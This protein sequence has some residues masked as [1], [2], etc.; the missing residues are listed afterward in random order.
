MPRMKSGAIKIHSSFRVTLHA[1]DF[2]T[3]VDLPKVIAMAQIAKI[4]LLLV[5]AQQV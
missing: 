3:T 2:L 5:Q 1:V 4:N